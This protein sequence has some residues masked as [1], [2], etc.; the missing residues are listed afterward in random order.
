M[1][2]DARNTFREEIRLASDNDFQH[3]CWK[4]GV[5]LFVESIIPSH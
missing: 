1:S 3:P 2:P 5:C 4:N